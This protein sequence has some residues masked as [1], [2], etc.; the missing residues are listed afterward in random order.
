MVNFKRIIF[1]SQYFSTKPYINNGK[2]IVLGIETSCDDTAVAIV[3]S[4][5]NILGSR[6]FSIKNAQIK[7]GGICPLVTQQIHRNYIDKAINESMKDAGIRFYDLD[8]IAVTSRPGI[9][10]CLRVGTDKAVNLAQKYNLPLI[11][12]HHMRGHALSGG[13]DKHKDLV[14]PFLTLL[15]SGGHALLAIGH[16]PVDFELIGKSDF[17]SP[18]ECLDKIGRKLGLLQLPEYKEY[19]TGAAIEEIASKAKTIEE[20]TKYQIPMPSIKGTNFDFAHIKNSYIT[21]LNKTPIE[22]IDL[23]SFCASSQFLVTAHICSKVHLALETLFDKEINVK[24]LVVSG[25]VASNQFIRGCLA[26]VCK[27]HSVEMI[28]PPKT[29]CTDNGEMIGWAGCEI[30]KYYENYK[31]SNEQKEIIYNIKDYIYAVGKELIGKDSTNNWSPPKSNR[32]FVLTSL[33][34]FSSDLKIKKKYKIT[35]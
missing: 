3:D 14:Y 29:L 4:D 10:L 12:I 9:V 30:L 11:P 15:I 16:S 20:Y 7:L 19:H 32:K 17:N 33:L 35:L 25:G 26:K 22:D 18:G 5:K 34:P 28:T 23:V 2:K 31:S 24:Q 21:F 13:L 8:A 1:L 27:I 6:N